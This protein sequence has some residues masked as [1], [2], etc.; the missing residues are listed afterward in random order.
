L[1]RQCREGDELLAPS[2]HIDREGTSSRHRAKYVR[3]FDDGADLVGCDWSARGV[4]A[5]RG[6]RGR[7]TWR[8]RRPVG[9]APVPAGAR[10]L[11]ANPGWGRHPG[12]RLGTSARR[13]RASSQTGAPPHVRGLTEG[14]GAASPTPVRRHGRHLGRHARPR[15]R[16]RLHRS[17]R[18][19]RASSPAGSALRARARGRAPAPV[20]TPPSPCCTSGSPQAACPCSRRSIPSCRAS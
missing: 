19:P 1:R 4:H 7:R 3:W 6:T 17:A 8:L 5:V 16:A 2:R 10:V 12:G 14:P 20:R 15:S 18:A 11:A 9:G 13:P